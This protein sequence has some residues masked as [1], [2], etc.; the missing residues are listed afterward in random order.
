M[1]KSD[2]RTIKKFFLVSFVFIILSNNF[3]NYNEIILYGQTDGTT[4]FKIAEAAPNIST[5]K[6]PYHKAQRFL[7]PY[8]TGVI[9]KYLI[10][11]TYTLFRVFSF[12][13]IGLI[14]FIFKKIFYKLNI[15]IN[16]KI[17]LFSLIIFNPYIIRYYLANPLMINDLLFLLSGTLLILSFIRSNKWLLLLSIF[18]ATISRL[19]SI[20]FIIALIIGKVIYEKKYTFSLNSILINLIIFL[21][22]FLLNDYHASIVGSD[23]ISTFT[24]EQR[25]GLFMFNYSLKEFLIFIILPFFNF[26]PIFLFFLF[27]YL[28]VS[29]HKQD[30]LFIFSIIIVFLTM[31]TPFIS[32]PIVTGK[33]IIRL[34][35]L[36]YPFMIYIFY[37]IF[38]I[39]KNLSLYK[40]TL[41]LFIVILWSLHPTYSKINIFLP[42]S[43]IFS[44]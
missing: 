1:I 32:G 3:F 24:L 37:K 23:D 33:N 40:K 14:L 12:F 13:L 18:I 22:I 20:F 19:E 9:S 17:F 10:V 8:I 16:F 36:S 4:Y 43:K 35:N 26:F 6:H 27:F 5:E 42:L 29:S 25:F 11:D 30:S 31:I 7:L 21:S 44:Y 15:E 41:F 2:S 28:K 39:K 34:I 38:I